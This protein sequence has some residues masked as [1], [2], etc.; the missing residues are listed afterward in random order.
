M[1]RNS[2]WLAG[3]LLSMLFLSG[4]LSPFANKVVSDRES[5]MIAESTVQKESTVQQENTVLQEST[6]QQESTRQQGSTEQ[7]DDISQT[8]S[9]I[10]QN[11]INRND[12]TPKADI[13]ATDE[14]VE[15]QG[16]PSELQVHFID[17]GQGDCTL[18]TCDGEAM[19]IDA[20]DNSKG[21][22]IQLYL[23]KHGIEKLKYVIGTHPDADHIGGLDVILYKYDCDTIILPDKSSD[24]G[25]YRDVIDTL[26]EKNYAI[27]LPV[28]GTEYELGNAKFVI[29]GPGKDYADDNNCSVVIKVTHGENTFL[30]TGDI[31]E[32]AENDYVTS[33]FDLSATVLK[34]AHHGSHSSTSSHFLSKVNPT[35]AVIS[36]GENNS[37][38][39]PHAEP[40]NNL[41]S[42][43]CLLYRTDEQGTTVVTSDG[44]T[45]TWNSSPSDTWQSGEA[46]GSSQTDTQAPVVVVPVLPDESVTPEESM[47][48]DDSEPSIPVA[49]YILNTNT[50]KFHYPSCSS[51]KDMKDKNKLES[52]DT[53][54][55]IISL[56]YVPCKRCN[57]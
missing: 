18:L 15:I 41:R 38:G 39:H 14:S 31:E 27:T 57:P 51:V 5:N 46:T 40:L 21:T 44:A 45:L 56:G 4:C 22:T 1:K 10:E 24:S 17:V 6:V 7:Q 3:C 52:C 2:K 28:V 23:K 36:C 30:F 20:G 16:T 37:Y 8:E 43:G 34:V 55:Y 26:D 25:T 54:E 50:K 9:A 12:D 35:Y 42:Q 49:L 53:R 48:P 19:L 47:V 32:E 13:Q 29:L 11:N 33:G